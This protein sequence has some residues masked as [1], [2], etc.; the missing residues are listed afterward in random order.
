MLKY[1]KR[2]I[3]LGKRPCQLPCYGVAPRSRLKLSPFE[4]L[5]GRP[6]QVSAWAGESIKSLKDL[7]VADYVKTLGT[8]PIS[9]HEFA[10]SRSAYPTE[11]ALHPFR[12]ADWVLLKTWREKGPEHQLTARWT[13]PHVVLLTTLSSVKLA[14]L[15]PWIKAAPPS[16]EKWLNSR[17]A[18]GKMGLWT[19]LRPKVALF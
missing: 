6:F 7:A 16:S 8:I 3:E 1:V 10:S 2:L 18:W 17:E 14:G 12:P 13:G 9:V 4:I 11:V 5:Y 15:K 19:L